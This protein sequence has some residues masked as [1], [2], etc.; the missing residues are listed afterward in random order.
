MP[1]SLKDRKE[2]DMMRKT[3]QKSEQKNFNSMKKVRCQVHNGRVRK[4]PS[5]KTM[6]SIWEACSNCEKANYLRCVH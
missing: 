2:F 3:R 6:P 4:L 5:G 1:E